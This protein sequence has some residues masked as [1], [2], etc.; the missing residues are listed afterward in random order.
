MQVLLE[1][2]AEFMLRDFSSGGRADDEGNLRI[3]VITLYVEGQLIAKRHKVLIFLTALLGIVIKPL[4][5][6]VPES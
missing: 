5:D 3:V 4:I 6:S 2:H 1:G